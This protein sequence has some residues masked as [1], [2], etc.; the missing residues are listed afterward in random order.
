MAEPE[1]NLQANEYEVQVELSDLQKDASH[2]LG[3]ASSFEDL[4]L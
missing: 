4:N 3:S 2:P 1:N